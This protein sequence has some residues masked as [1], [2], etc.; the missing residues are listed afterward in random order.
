MTPP[1]PADNSTNTASA[2]EL[3]PDTVGSESVIDVAVRFV[4]EQPG[5]VGR[6]LARHRQLAD[7][8]CAGCV[9]SLTP[10]PCSVASIALSAQ[11]R[12]I[13][14]YPLGVSRGGRGPAR[15]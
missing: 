11:Q 4:A 10:W 3:N 13:E 9:T 14:A 6:M 2:D 8:Q 5:G 12:L 15:P 1:R 7:G